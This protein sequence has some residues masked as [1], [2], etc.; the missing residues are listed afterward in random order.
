MTGMMFPDLLQRFLPAALLP[1]RAE[2]LERSWE[3]AWASI[4][5]AGAAARR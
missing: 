1:D 2:T 5:P 4:D 3:A